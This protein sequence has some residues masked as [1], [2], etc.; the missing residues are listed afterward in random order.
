MKNIMLVTA[1]LSILGVGYVAFSAN[2]ASAGLFDQF[3]TADW[4]TKKSNAFKV[5][6][7]GFDFRV[8][9]WQTEND[10]NTFCTVAIGNADQAPYMGLHCFQKSK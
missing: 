7:Y 10:P 4:P 3:M 8:Y 5:E 9:E 2:Q 1:A 6:A